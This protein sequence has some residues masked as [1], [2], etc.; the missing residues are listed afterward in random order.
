MKLNRRQVVATAVG[1]GL[2]AS[3]LPASLTLGA[4]KIR[5]K[6]DIPTPALL[7][8]LDRFESNLRT[9][10]EQCKKTSCGLR[11]H[12][13]THKCPEIAKRQIAAG[14]LGICVATVPE[15]EAMAAAGIEGILLT[16]P[17][18][19]PSKIARLTKLIRNG[20]KLMVSVGHP[21]EVQLLAEA[22]AADNVSVDLLIDLDVG[23]RRSGIL[24][25]KPA[26][27]F[28][29]Q[30]KRH[31]QLKIRGVQA[32]AGLASH[33][34]GYQA[35]KRKSREVMADAVETRGQLRQ[36]GFD[37]A[38]LSGGSTGTYNID[39]SLAGMTE[40]QAGSYVFMDVDYRKI[41]GLDGNAV[42]KDFQ[43]ALT[44]LATVVNATHA[45]RVSI[46]A[47]TKAIDTTTTHKPEP[48]DRPGLIYSRA[49][50]E[51]GF[52]TV[53]NGGKLPKIGERVEFIVP[54]CDPTVHLHDRLY[55]VKG[56]EVVDIWPTVA[57]REHG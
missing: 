55:V 5:T 18:V 9:M 14:A 37:A 1:N 42:Y 53:E 2:L 30:I 32:Y 3:L 16:S 51:F 10:A 52:L 4:D 19:E 39:S 57:R 31:T 35:R 8:D 13:K 11:P 54:H 25:G 36:A 50:D 49:G 41:G 20:A 26:V 47:G 23:D 34:V 12:A 17:V 28:A 48:V 27:E 33:V 15:A 40:L 44:V 38:I 45:D 56:D 29:K 6:A 22:A 43:P 24:P 21:R 7:V 46:D